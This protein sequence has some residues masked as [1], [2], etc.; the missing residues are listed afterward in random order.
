VN[1]DSKLIGGSY[2]ARIAKKWLKIF[3]NSDVFFTSAEQQPSAEG[4][5]RTSTRNLPPL[6]VLSILGSAAATARINNDIG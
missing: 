6:S 3:I 4:W 5:R 2:P 1:I